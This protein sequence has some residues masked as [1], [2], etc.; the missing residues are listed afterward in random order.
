[1]SLSPVCNR[2]LLARGKPS[3]PTGQSRYELKSDVD[4]ASEVK[5]EFNGFSTKN[6]GP[7]AK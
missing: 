5:Y 4:V 6:S 7:T 3:T 2:R 1:M